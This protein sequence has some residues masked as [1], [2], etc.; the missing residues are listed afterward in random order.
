MELAVLTG[1][2]PSSPL[3][4]HYEILIF[5]KSTTLCRMAGSSKLPWTQGDSAGEDAEPPWSTQSSVMALA[6]P[7][8]RGNYSFIHEQE[9]RDEPLANFRSNY[10]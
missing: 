9:H 8:G 7:E 1:V 4:R 6:K 3:I 5:E 2:Q 10:C